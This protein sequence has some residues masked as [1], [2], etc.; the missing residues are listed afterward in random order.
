MTLPEL[1]NALAAHD[2]HHARS[3]DPRVARDGSRS[4]WRLR[5]ASEG[6]GEAGRR[7]FADFSAHYSATG[8]NRPL[9]PRPTTAE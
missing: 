1:W 2:W 5:E 3:D 4:W 7:M 9:P 6:L 8:G